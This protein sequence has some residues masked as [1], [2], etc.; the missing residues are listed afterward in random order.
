[1]EVQVLLYPSVGGLAH[2]CNTSQYLHPCIACAILCFKNQA[3]PC[4]AHRLG[5]Q[6]LLNLL[7]ATKRAPHARFHL[8]GLA[9]ASGAC[10][11]LFFQTCFLLLRESEREGGPFLAFLLLALR[12]IGNTRSGSGTTMRVWWSL[13]WRLI[14]SLLPKVNPRNFVRGPLM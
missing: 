4:P 12:V 3:M 6:D 10:G 7:Q 1:M 14:H 2:R 13:R 8:P 9:T 5:L 11:E